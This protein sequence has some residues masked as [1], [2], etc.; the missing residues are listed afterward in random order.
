MKR[1]DF[2]G[3]AGLGIATGVA[4]TSALST[5][6]IAQSKKTITIVS[7]WG[8]DFL[9]LGTSA[10]RLAARVTE[11]S[12]GAL[13]T[14]YFAAGEKVGAFDVFDEVASG[15]STAYISADYYWIGKHPGFAYFTSV[16]F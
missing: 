9:G 3:K 16:P 1:R 8:R 4:A 10:Q 7:S 5:P 11:L 2:I 14:E 13:T 15:N 12:Q 6:A